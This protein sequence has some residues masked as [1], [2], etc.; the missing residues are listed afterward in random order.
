MQLEFEKL[1][2]QTVTGIQ[3]EVAALPA[4]GQAG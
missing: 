1:G 2:N 4:V 3:R